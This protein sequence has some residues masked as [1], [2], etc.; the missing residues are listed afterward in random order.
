MWKFRCILPHQHFS[1]INFYF[2]CFTIRILIIYSMNDNLTWHDLTMLKRNSF[3]LSVIKI[4]LYSDTRSALHG[5][6][7][8]IHCYVSTVSVKYK[9]IQNVKYEHPK[10]NQSWIFTGRTDAEAETLIL[11]PLEMKSWLTGKD[12]DAG[13]DWRWEEKGMTKDEMV[14]WHHWLNGHEFE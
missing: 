5:L 13:K 11:W 12:P 9:Y 7:I 4:L 6:C 8:N 2:N 1:K 3:C 10:G 14:G